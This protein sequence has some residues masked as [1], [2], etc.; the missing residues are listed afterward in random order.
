MDDLGSQRV[1]DFLINGKEPSDLGF[2][3]RSG[4]LVAWHYTNKTWSFEEWLYKI[5]EN[6]NRSIEKRTLQPN[7]KENPK[8]HEEWDPHEEW[9]NV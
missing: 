2:P 1:S 7:I 6:H 9:D 4:A 3:S 8:E 5:L